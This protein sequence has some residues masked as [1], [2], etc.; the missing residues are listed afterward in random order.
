ML[1]LQKNCSAVLQFNDC[2]KVG[3]SALTWESNDTPSKDF[4][5]PLPNERRRTTLIWKVLGMTLL[6]GAGGLTAHRLS[7]YERKRIAVMN[8]WLDLLYY[9]RTGI[10]CYLTPLEELFS[11][12][13]ASL[14]RACMGDNSLQTPNAL[15]RRSKPY[16]DRESADLLESFAREIGGCYRDEQVRRCDYYI[17]TLRALRDKQKS[18][19]PG[20]LRTRTM[21]CVCGAFGLAIMLW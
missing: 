19:L 1:A 3:C 2:T 4:D 20:R 10:D 7:H 6:L 5:I 14:L 13:P 17:A 21:L 11:K 16:L 15:L 9:I 12:A 8:G 18:E